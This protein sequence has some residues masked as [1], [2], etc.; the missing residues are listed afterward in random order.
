M[1][2]LT[3]IN[4]DNP[5]SSTL[6]SVV[7]SFLILVLCPSRLLVVWSSWSSYRLV[8]SLFLSRPPPPLSCVPFLRRF[9]FRTLSLPFPASPR[10]PPLSLVIVLHPLLS[11]KPEDE[12]HALSPESPTL[13]A[14]SERLRRNRIRPP[15]LP[16][17]PVGDGSGLSAPEPLVRGNKV[18]HGAKEDGEEPADTGALGNV[19]LA[20]CWRALA[21]GVCA[22]WLAN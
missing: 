17:C 21:K 13:T 18:G 10:L 4:S 12:S 1:L 7:Q 22:V 15:P 6:C 3:C 19:G 8:P 2:C 9:L 5:C 14:V 11:L 20:N 16:R